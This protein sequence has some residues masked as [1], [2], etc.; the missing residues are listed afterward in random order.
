MGLTIAEDAY[1]QWSSKCTHTFST[2]IA[3]KSNYRSLSFPTMFYNQ[4]PMKEKKPTNLMKEYKLSRLK[5][6]SI[7]KMALFQKDY[8]LTTS[9]V[10]IMYFKLRT[11]WSAQAK[12]S[13]SMKS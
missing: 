4:S 7:M 9:Y 6:R 10:Q 8:L 13:E 2:L 1:V 11:I 5:S 3:G 12:K